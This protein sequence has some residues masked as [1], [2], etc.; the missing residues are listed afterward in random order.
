MVSDSCCA[1]AETLSWRGF[2]DFA[3]AHTLRFDGD[4]CHGPA[5]ASIMVAISDGYRPARPASK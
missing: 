5:F 4:G 1:A 2:A 3:L